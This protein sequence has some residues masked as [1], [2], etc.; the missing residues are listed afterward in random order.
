MKG[1]I[2]ALL[3]EE[4]WDW[5]RDWGR[6]I[7]TFPSG[8]PASEWDVP[9]DIWHWDNPTAWNRKR[10]TG[11]FIVACVNQV[12]PAH[13][14]TLVLA[15]SPQLVLRHYETLPAE[16]RALGHIYE[17]GRFRRSDPWLATLSGHAPSP[18]DRIAAFM[19]AGGEV[20]GVRVRVVELTGEP[21]DVVFCH[22]LIVHGTAPNCGTAPRMMRIKQ[23]FKSREAVRLT[24]A[25]EAARK[26]RA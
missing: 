11:L 8:R 12:R 10:L 25:G 22:P 2:D 26:G 9:T 14:G 4:E 13:G 1:A 16:K 3:G 19:Q 18:P 23:H 21:G 5:P 7:V 15:G 17:I 24:K 20:G 6:A